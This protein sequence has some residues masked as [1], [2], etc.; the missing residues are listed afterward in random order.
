M[1]KKTSEM[2]TKNYK[3]T[4]KLSQ[5]EL[6]LNLKH[7]RREKNGLKTNYKTTHFYLRNFKDILF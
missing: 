3:N 1:K 4:F 6:D 5:L 2:T 7:F